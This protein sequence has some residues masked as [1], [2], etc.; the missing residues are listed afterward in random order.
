MLINGEIDNLDYL[1]DSDNEYEVPRLKL[2]FQATNLILPAEIWGSIPRS[3]SMGGTYILYNYDEFL[4]P[5]WRNPMKLIVSG[6]YQI[7]EINFSCTKDMPFPVGLYQIYRKRWM[8]RYWAENHN[9]KILV[10]MN[11]HEKFAELNMLGIPQ[12]WKAYITH[13]FSDFS[14]LLDRQIVRARERAGVDDIL[15]VVYGGGKKIRQWCLDNKA[16]Y[17][18]RWINREPVENTPVY[19]EGKEERKGLGLVP[20]IKLNRREIE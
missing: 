9:L 14:D 20:K 10:D 15:F 6:C 3:R 1:Y 5:L 18:E 2:E 4:V 17:I 12:G 11:A 13:G 16:M 7:G 8:S 19:L